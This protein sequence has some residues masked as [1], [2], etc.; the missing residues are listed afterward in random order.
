MS[1]KEEV[2]NRAIHDELI[3]LRTS[4]KNI[5]TDL[6]EIINTIQAIN[7]G[8]NKIYESVDNMIAFLEDMMGEGL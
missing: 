1:G 3:R 6:D 5:I 4:I 2:L 7:K 8:L